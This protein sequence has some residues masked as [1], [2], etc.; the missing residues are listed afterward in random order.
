VT[1]LNDPYQLIKA[2]Q[3]FLTS[4]EEFI[5]CPLYTS[6]KDLESA[7]LP[8]MQTQFGF[9][10]YHNWEKVFSEPKI[11]KELGNIPVNHY[12]KIDM[13]KDIAA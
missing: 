6:Y 13:D 5:S 11:R 9:T 3:K 4:V 7:L 2:K 8:A 1:P 12:G 10:L